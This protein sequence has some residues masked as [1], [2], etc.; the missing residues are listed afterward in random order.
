MGKDGEDILRTVPLVVAI[1]VKYPKTVYFSTLLMALVAAYLSVGFFNLD[2]PL[3]GLRIRDDVV[4]ER[5]D[6]WIQ[7]LRND[8]R[9]ESGDSNIQRV[10]ERTAETRELTLLYIAEESNPDNVFTLENIAKMAALE[11][12]LVA[13]AG[14]DEFCLFD[15]DDAACAEVLSPLRY[16]RNATTPAEIEDG[17]QAMWAD[18]DADKDASLVHFCD[19]FDN[20]TNVQCSKT[21][22]IIRFGL[23]LEGYLNPDDRFQDQFK[24]LTDYLWDGGERDDIGPGESF[25]DIM[26]EARE[27]FLEDPENEMVVTFFQKGIFDR[28]TLVILVGDL[29]FAAASFGMVALIIGLHTGSWYLSIMSLVQILLSFPLCFFIYRAIFGIELFGGLNI[30]SIYLLLGIATDDIFIYTDAFKQSRALLHGPGWTLEK[31]LAWTF[32]RAAYTMATTTTTT[33][34]AFLT[35]ATSIIPIIRYF[36]IFTSL[37]LVVNFFT[38]V[39]MYSATLVFWSRNFEEGDKLC[40]CGSSSSSSQDDAKVLAVESGGDADDE[41]SAS[42]SLSRVE[43]FFRDRFS[44]DF[45]NTVKGRRIV[46]SFFAVL[47]IVAI[48][49]AAQLELASNAV[50][51]WEPD[52]PFG[53]ALDN[54]PESFL[55]SE[56]ESSRDTVKL[57]WG[58]KDPF[59]DREGTKETLDDDFGEAIFDP[60]FVLADEDAQVFLRDVCYEVVRNRTNALFLDTALDEQDIPACFMAAFAKWREARGEPFPV[61]QVAPTNN[62]ILDSGILIPETSSVESFED[63]L[64]EF[65]GRPQF[66]IEF[67]ASVGFKRDAGPTQDRLRASFA[68][69]EFA[70]T[71]TDDDSY[72]KRSDVV[73]A[74]DSFLEQMQQEEPA[75][76][77]ANSYYT[78][79]FYFVW[80]RTQ[81]LFVTNVAISI[82][83]SFLLAFTVSTIATRNY[84]VAAIAS[85]SI[86][87]VVLYVCAAI[88]LFGFDLGSIESVVLTLVIG[89][90]VDYI[91][92][93]AV[94]YSDAQFDRKLDSRAERVEHAMMT[95]GTSILAGAVST[96]LATSFLLLTTIVFFSK[97]GKLTTFTIVMAA[98]TA[99]ILFPAILAAVGP[100]KEQGTVCVPRFLREEMR[101]HKEKGI[102]GASAKSTRSESIK[103]RA[104]SVVK[105]TLLAYLSVLV[106]A[107][108]V[109]VVMWAVRSAELDAEEEEDELEDATAFVYDDSVF[110]PSFA[111][112]EEGVWT[113]MRPGGD[114]LCARGTPYAFF[115]K[116][117]APGAPIIFEFEGGGA[118]WNPSTCQ[119]ATSTFKDTV[120]DTR[121]AFQRIRR[122]EQ[123][124]SGLMDELG[125]YSSFTHIFQAYCT[126]DLHWGNNTVE[127]TD[128]LTIRHRGAV[129][130]KAML[131]WVAA[132]VPEAPRA[133]VTG[134]SA[135]SY[136]S[137]FHG[138]NIAKLFEDQGFSTKLYQMGDSGM[139]IIS[140][141]FL[142]ESFPSWKANETSLFPEFVAPGGTPLPIDVSSLSLPLLY[143]W[144]ANRFETNGFVFS[145]FSAA[146]D[147]NQAFFTKTI[148][149]GSSQEVFS[150]DKISWNTKMET[151]YVPFDGVA[152]NLHRIIGPGD[153][154]CAVPGNRFWNVDAGNGVKL[155]KV[156]HDMFISDTPPVGDI[157]CADISSCENGVDLRPSIDLF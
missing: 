29:T 33:A 6:G 72:A 40:C 28:E 22:T 125:P 157:N 80:W 142:V 102:K 119:K 148:E 78:D 3:V 65:L 108:I 61:P 34:F 145:Q 150:V 95:L 79:D 37:L 24:L 156:L 19:E 112:L 93:V 98:L 50:S 132:E 118:C 133:L 146:Y 67:F 69:Q 1:S 105:K 147:W 2:N 129:N 84:I 81:F 42:R 152:P 36:G 11:D 12:Q 47:T 32:H 131:D 44:R 26:S 124:P 86:L 64:S 15:L 51:F 59:V 120:E 155:H 77:G 130:V 144:V 21:R 66:G 9:P 151:A 13:V 154:H 43:L 103:L 71:T 35:L 73:E 38:V 99:L 58:L 149:V 76:L 31:R 117:G 56:R 45:I 20:V 88:V 53:I 92:H 5:S 55:K 8:L 136:G 139:G 138:A 74:W 109:F 97:F 100:E 57:V 10:T 153:Y 115:V 48:V 49:F 85:C 89:I 111:S 121:A 94:G 17:L 106:A 39:T 107:V 128:S 7:A 62:Q 113:E 126:G 52:H 23:P 90:S 60:S 16:V 25:F 135:G 4:A 68:W 91:I 116:K 127:Y 70:T 134:C 87:L 123:R 14:Y 122:G 140:D 104:D 41:T 54:L 27:K 18:I 83:C 96:F 110:M 101:Q 114:T 137:L 143:Q 30:I 63:S 141:T 75:T 46:F 82:S